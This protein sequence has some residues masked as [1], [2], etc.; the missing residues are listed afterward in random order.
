MTRRSLEVQPPDKGAWQQYFTLGEIFRAYGHYQE[1][2]KNL[3]H[4][5]ELR[6]GFEPAQI[7]LKEMESLPT[8][9]IHIYT[10]VIIVCLVRM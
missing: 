9:T 7:A 5:L 8:A 1:A 6:P 3:K 10:L 2:I 4:T